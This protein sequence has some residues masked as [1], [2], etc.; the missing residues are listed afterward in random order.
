L[1]KA[2]AVQRDHRKSRPQVQRQV[3]NSSCHRGHR[4]IPPFDRHAR[5][6]AGDTLLKAA[7]LRVEKSQPE[8]HKVDRG[9]CVV[10]QSAARRRG[11]GIF[12]S[13]S[14]AAG[15]RWLAQKWTTHPVHQPAIGPA[16]A[17]LHN[18]ESATVAGAGKHALGCANPR[19]TFMI[20]ALAVFAILA[21]VLP[22]ARRRQ[23]PKVARPRLA[24]CAPAYIAT[25]PV[26]AF[27]DPAN[28]GTCAAPAAEIN[29]RAC[30]NAPACRFTVTGAKRRR[31]ALL[32]AV[33]KRHRRYRLFWPS[34][35]WRAAQVDFSQKLFAGAE[36]PTW[37][38]RIHRSSRSPMRTAAGVRIGVGARD[39]G[40]Y[41]LT[42]ALKQRRAQTQR[43]R[44]LGCDR[45]SAAR[46]RARWPMR[47]NRMRLA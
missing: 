38:P 27:V 18:I 25:N 46:R 7:R 10:P 43:R 39:A 8:T 12:F 35:R 34:I 20:R 14:L 3:A 28:Q 22:A 47:A 9:P 42:K 23:A 17:N 2:G 15:P 45:R 1:A 32:E 24:R 11:R 31:G 4:V 19:R 13:K 21:A 30:Q 44:H 33:K 36:T 6:R 16:P 40:D 41:F 37:S 5:D 26:Q 29:A